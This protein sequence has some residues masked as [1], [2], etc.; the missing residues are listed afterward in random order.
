MA[1]ALHFAQ[2]ADV[3]VSDRGDAGMNLGAQA[4]RLLRDCCNQLN[5]MGDLDFVLL[6]GDLLDTSSKS[7]LSAVLDSL[8]V[9]Q[10]PWHFIA[11]NHDGFHDRRYPDALTPVEVVTAIDSRLATL[12]P[13][14]QNAVWSRPVAPGVQ[15]IG[16][17]SRI[18]ADW[19]G[20]IGPRQLGWLREQ[21]HEH[22]NKTV[23]IAVHHPLYPLTPHNKRTWWEKFI[24][25]NGREVGHLLDQYPNVKMVISGHHHANQ[26][27]A[28]NGRLH[29]TTAAL[30]GYPCIFRTIRLTERSDGW[31]AALQVHRVA[32]DATLERARAL[33]RTSHPSKDF[34]PGDPD[35]YLAFCDGEP[36]DRTFNGRII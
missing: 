12:P 8:A 11:G 25:S 14:V 24:C 33:M 7:E 10:K 15:L 1:V 13:Y 22:R 3:H 31:H 19:A 23:M 32:D 36:S 6:T 18:R 5:E 35:A 27:L 28:R 20:E 2:I 9:L 29:V 30:G 16:L 34:V 17:D 26:I 21:L 4:P